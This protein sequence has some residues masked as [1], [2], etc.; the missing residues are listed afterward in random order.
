MV[1]KVDGAAVVDEVYEGG[2]LALAFHFW[3]LSLGRA[4]AREGDWGVRL[5]DI[6]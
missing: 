5:S 3:F 4:H 1:G 6:S 2:G